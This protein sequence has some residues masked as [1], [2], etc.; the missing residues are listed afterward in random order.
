MEML[1]FTWQ[2]QKY[3]RPEIYV[4]CACSSGK[5][6]TNDCRTVK[7]SEYRYAKKC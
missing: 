4:A 5:T 6:N 3:V 1:D 7:H 2:H